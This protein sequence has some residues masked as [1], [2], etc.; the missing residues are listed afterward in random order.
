M[1]MGCESHFQPDYDEDIP[2]AVHNL[3]EGSIIASAMG[4]ITSQLI[5]TNRHLAQVGGKL[6]SIVSDK[7]AFKDERCIF[8]QLKNE[9]RQLNHNMTRQKSS[10]D[11]LGRSVQELVS[12]NKN[13]RVQQEN[14]LQA[15]ATSVDTF[16]ATMT[17]MTGAFQLLTRNLV[18]PDQENQPRQSRDSRDQLKDDRRPYHGYKGLPPRRSLTDPLNLEPRRSAHHH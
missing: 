17:T 4:G 13:K 8:N 11:T 18:R 10:I 1:D 3:Q 12:L 2:V 15:L 16:N 5:T 9:L 6:D 14:L 7:D